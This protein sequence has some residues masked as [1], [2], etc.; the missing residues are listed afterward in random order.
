MLYFN[1]SNYHK[2]VGGI[3]KNIEAYLTSIRTYI[4]TYIHSSGEHE[5]RFR[6]SGLRTKCKQERDMLCNDRK[7]VGF[8]DKSC[9]SYGV[10]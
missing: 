8:T 5:E 9:E 7:P 6:S 1:T 3:I 4:R 2:L 10:R